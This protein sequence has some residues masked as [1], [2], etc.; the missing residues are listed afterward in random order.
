MSLYPTLEDM[1]VS[2]MAQTQMAAESAMQQQAI[3]VAGGG[4]S[5]GEL[6]VGPRVKERESMGELGVGPR[7][8]EGVR[9]KERES[10]GE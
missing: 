1:E 8:K 5:M 2:N 3:A 9:V 6:G 10:M 7:V 4:E